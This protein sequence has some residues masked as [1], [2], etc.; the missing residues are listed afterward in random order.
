[1]STYF[2]VTT[3]IVDTI[4]MSA[5]GSPVAT[6][7][8][9]HVGDDQDSSPMYIMWVDTKKKR[10]Q[11]SSIEL[12]SGDIL[13]STSSTQVLGATLQDMRLVLMMLVCNWFNVHRDVTY[14]FNWD[15][16]GGWSS[17]CCW[18]T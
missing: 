11:R 18:I 9:M 3:R 8:S 17:L 15:P 12:P 14:Y 10:L 13:T 4:S 6:S 7:F 1:M 5:Y 2:D 16:G